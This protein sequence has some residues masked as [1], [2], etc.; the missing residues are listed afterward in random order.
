MET[1]VWFK[2]QYVSSNITARKQ[3]MIVIILLKLHQAATLKQRM[4]HKTFEVWSISV[5]NTE[6]LATPKY[7]T[8][9]DL[10]LCHFLIIQ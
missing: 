1:G 7:N 4:L 3:N 2:Y 8:I 9:T 6:K 10:W 5:I